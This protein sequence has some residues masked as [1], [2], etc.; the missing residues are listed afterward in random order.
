MRNCG[1]PEAAPVLF[2]LRCP[3]RIFEISLFWKHGYGFHFNADRTEDRTFLQ[4]NSEEDFVMDA[5]HDCITTI[6]RE[7][8][9]RYPAWVD[10]GAGNTTMGPAV[11]F[12]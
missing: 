2:Q 3:R 12:P 8:M 9:A 10:H 1:Y 4:F 11:Q 7:Y 5:L 6:Y